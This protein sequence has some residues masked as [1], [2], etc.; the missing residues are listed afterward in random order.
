MGI[1]FSIADR[2][3]RVCRK[4]RRRT[5]GLCRCA[6][7]LARGVGTATIGRMS[8]E[9]TKRDDDGAA[10]A[11]RDAVFDRAAGRYD[12][13]AALYQ[14]VGRRLLERCDH[15][16]REPLRILDLGCGTGLAAADLK[17]KYRKAQVIGVDR[18]M[19]MLA[20]QRGR[21]SILRPL[22]GVCGDIG[23]LPFPRACADL[24]FANLAVPW[25]AERSRV[26]DEFRRLLR[27]GGLLLFS[28]FGPST[29]RELERLG[30]GLELPEYPD[31]LAIGDELV[32]A[33]FREP[34]MDME[35]ITLEYRSL[36][37][38][39]GEVEATG[40]A[41]LVGHWDSWASDPAARETARELLHREGKYPLGFE[42]VYGT[43]FGPEEGQPRR[44]AGGEE[45]TFSVDS[46]LKSRRIR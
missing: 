44:T 31:L 4:Y 40:T 17:R 13:F 27:P 8:A 23:A 28:T 42:V 43:A 2:Q 14:E 38:L 3:V 29:L 26:F 10:L 39:V 34:V 15:A 1:S 30:A 22:R 12:D 6:G 35:R 21:S 16:R 9:H 36:D 5:V 46:L 20:R 32:A 19:A 41:L 45:A 33:G 7:S 25:A 24:L 18:S 11:Q 37:D